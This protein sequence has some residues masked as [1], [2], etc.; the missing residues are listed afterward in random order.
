VEKNK[1]MKTSNKIVIG[2]SA[3]VVAGLI[4]A[5]AKKRVKRKILTTVSDHG[6][7]TAHDVLYPEGKKK[8]RKLHYGPVLPA[9]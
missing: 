6:Y 4:V 3:V 2:L 5:L 8:F 7:E 9:L 1:N